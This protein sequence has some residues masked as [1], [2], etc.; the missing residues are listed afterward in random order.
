MTRG[1]KHEFN[2]RINFVI[3]WFVK[4]NNFCYL[5]ILN[6]F[7]DGYKEK[8]EMIMMALLYRG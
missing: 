5:A 3:M 1:M 2:K 8:D 4:F 7:I 6:Y